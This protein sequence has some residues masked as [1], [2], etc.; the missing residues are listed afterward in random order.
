MKVTARLS[1]RVPA[2]GTA[3]GNIS[4]PVAFGLLGPA[5][6]GADADPGQVSQD[7]GGQFGGCNRRDERSADKRVAFNATKGPQ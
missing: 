5:F 2:A 3:F 4:N 1:R 6:C 7:R